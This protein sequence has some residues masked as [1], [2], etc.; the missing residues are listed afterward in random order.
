MFTVLTMPILAHA[1]TTTN[2]Q[3][4]SWGDYKFVCPADSATLTPITVLAATGEHNTFL[5]QPIDRF[6]LSTKLY[7]PID[8]FFLST[9]LY[10]P[11]DRFFLST[12]LYSWSCRTT[13]L[14]EI[15]MIRIVL[16]T[17]L[18][19][20]EPGSEIDDGFALALAIADPDIKLELVTT[21]NGN[22]DVE[23][24]TLLSL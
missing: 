6:F 17:D 13:P 16:D 23:T 4:G 22:T 15:I 8:R 1:N 2:D 5:S 10:R 21:V 18:G 9:K 14:E 3:N 24:A 12:K 19:M 20:G 7:R 11:I